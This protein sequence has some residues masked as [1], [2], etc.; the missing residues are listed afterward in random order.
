MSLW[1]ANLDP[2]RIKPTLKDICEGSY[3]SMRHPTPPHFVDACSPFTIGLNRMDLR[4]GSP[5][6]TCRPIPPYSSIAWL[7]LCTGLSLILEGFITHLPRL[8]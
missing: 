5:I 4:E 3:V 7:P 2:H 1:D 8:N 6:L